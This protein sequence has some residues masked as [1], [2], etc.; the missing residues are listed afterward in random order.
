MLSQKLV[1]MLVMATL[2][3]ATLVT[4]GAA[5][6]TRK[7]DKVNQDTEGAAADESKKN[8]QVRGSVGLLDEFYYQGG[9]P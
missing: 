3:V 4:D 8:S 6:E 9:G 2:L 7:D 5:T 1:V